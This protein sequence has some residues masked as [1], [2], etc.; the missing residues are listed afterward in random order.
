MCLAIFCNMSMLMKLL[1]RAALC[2]ASIICC[3]ARQGMMRGLLQ[4]AACT[5][6]VA[7]L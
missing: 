6:F 7:T 1:G 5:L 2:S 4:I 3:A